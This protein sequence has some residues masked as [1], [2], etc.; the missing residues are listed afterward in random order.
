VLL[1]A[2]AGFT[3][4]FVFSLTDHAQNGLL[5]THERVPVR[6]SAIAVDS[7]LVP[8]LVRVN[9]AYL[10]IC[11]AVL[12]VQVILVCSARVLRGGR[13]W[14]ARCIPARTHPR[15]CAPTAPVLLPDLVFLALTG[16][17]F[18]ARSLENARRV[19]ASSTPDV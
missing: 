11:A 10:G 5:Q 9:R 1:L 6:S 13:P 3:G 4:N 17:C 16:L 7:L 2:L 14:S 18:L 19:S 15:R 12:L 8:F